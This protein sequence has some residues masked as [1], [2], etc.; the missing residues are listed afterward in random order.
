MEN[1]KNYI[2]T[3][4]TYWIKS[5]CWVQETLAVLRRSTKPPI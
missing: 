4:V 1:L 2:K 3:K 5:S